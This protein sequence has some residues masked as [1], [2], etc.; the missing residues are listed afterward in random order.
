RDAIDPTKY[1]ARVAHDIAMREAREDTPSNS[2]A[3]DE[4]HGISAD[5][6]PESQPPS[7][8]LTDVLANDPDLLSYAAW[9]ARSMKHAAA[10]RQLGW[11]SASARA[12]AVQQR[13]LGWRS[14]LASRKGTS[15][16]S[17]ASRTTFYEILEDG[18]RG[19]APPRQ[20]KH[21]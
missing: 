6:I 8:S 9:R 1:I 14:W 20:G 13:Y 10:C 17:D 4:L 21:R 19:S 3:L 7:Y 5:D 15:A 12:K 16:I 2:V 18:K 11:Q